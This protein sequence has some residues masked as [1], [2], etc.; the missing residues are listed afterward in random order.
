MTPSSASLK[1]SALLLLLLPAP[2][3]TLGQDG[4][5]G[6]DVEVPVVRPSQEVLQAREEKQREEAQAAFEVADYNSDGW[7]SFREAR[8]SQDMD[9]TRFHAID[10][11]GDG[12]ISL[13]EFTA[14]YLKSIRQVGAFKTPR[15]DPEAVT[16]PSVE[17]LAETEV[18]PTELEAEPAPTVEPLP[19]T[20]PVTGPA[21]APEPAVSVVELFGASKPREQSFQSSPEPPQ[22]VG[23]VP[24]FRRVDLDNDGAVTRTDLVE[25][26]RG[27]GLDVRAN[28]VLAAL[29]LDGDGGI[30][31]EEFYASMSHEDRSG[32]AARER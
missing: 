5:S 4:E 24:S 17:E 22:I 16:A 18:A 8:E 31:Q 23:P 14:Q 27:A 28:A 19:V 3:W 7:I 30:S 20:E 15:P 29:D 32:P 12:R 21:P 13:E 26:S 10:K 2:S 1:L 6:D 11:D 25:L 9:R